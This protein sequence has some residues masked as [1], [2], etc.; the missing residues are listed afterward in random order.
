MIATSDLLSPTSDLRSPVV[1]SP[2]VPLPA[3]R[4]PLPSDLCPL[5][6]VLCPSSCSPSFS[7]PLTTPFSTIGQCA[8]FIAKSELT[9]GGSLPACLCGLPPQRGP[10][11]RPSS[12]AAKIMQVRLGP[13]PRLGP[14]HPTSLR[15]P[16][17]TDYAS[18]PSPITDHNLPFA[19]CSLP[20]LTRAA[21]SKASGL[22]GETP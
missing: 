4:C 8:T 16:V 9:T 5:S 15:P 22:D 7:F 3:A 6:S 20:C 17:P 10:F 11:P 21:A 1:S 19:P 13:R 14:D 2:V 18:R 12:R